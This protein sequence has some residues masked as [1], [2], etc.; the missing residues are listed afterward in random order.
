MPLHPARPQLPPHIDHASRVVALA[1]LAGELSYHAIRAQLDAERWGR[2]G[3]AVVL[4]NARPTA[5][6]WR[7]VLLINCGPRALLTSFTAL[8]E[9]GLRRWERTA[10]HVLVPYGVRPPR[11]RGLVVHRIGD[12]GRVEAHRE[13]QLQGLAQSL[14]I[15]ASSFRSTRSATGILAAAV[16]Q[17]LLRP[18]EVRAALLAAPRTRH[19]RL[20]LLSVGDIEQGA[21]AL[22]EIDLGRLCWRFGLPAPTRQ[23]VRVD[24]TGRR[25]YLDGEW[26]LPD[27]RVVAIEVDGAHH[28]AVDTWRADQLRQNDIVLGGTTVLRYPSVVVRDEPELVAAQLRQ[29]LADLG[30]IRRR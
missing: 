14:V 7:R 18:G 5:W 20:L 21:D 6:E 4:H 16:Q 30:A 8:E 11:F 19:R 27:G 28:I 15:A 26:D 9:W 3:R 12:W 2:Y 29:A 1:D 22:S 25:R 10:A 24:S 13:R 23:S 17:G